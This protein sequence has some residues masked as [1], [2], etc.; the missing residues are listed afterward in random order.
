[1]VVQCYHLSIVQCMQT[2]A[3]A[4]LL[5]PSDVSNLSVCRLHLWEQHGSA[6]CCR[7]IPRHRYLQMVR[8]RPVNPFPMSY[9]KMS[10]Q[11]FATKVADTP[12]AHFA[13]FRDQMKA[14]IVR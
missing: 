13:S 14:E 5:C 4:E 2:L 12:V 8:A 6:V 7:I 11:L 9:L 3:A 10:D 1:M